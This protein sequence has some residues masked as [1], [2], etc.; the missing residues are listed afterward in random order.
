MCPDEHKPDARVRVVAQNPGEHEILGRRFVRWYKGEEGTGEIWEDYRPAPLIGKSGWELD[1]QFLPRAGLSRDDVECCNVV[2]CRLNNSNDLPPLT[3]TMAREMVTHCQRA[4]WKEPHD[5]QTMVA[6]G[7]YALWALTGE[8]EGDDEDADAADDDLRASKSIDGWR[9][10]LL[11]YAPVHA[12]HGV[13]FM[14]PRRS[15]VGD[16]PGRS[17]VFATYHPAFYYR[18]HWLKPVGKADFSK[19]GR[20]LRGVWPEPFPEMR[21]G[22]APIVPQ[23]PLAFDTEYNPWT[24]E[25]HRYSLAWRSQDRPVVWVTEAGDQVGDHGY[26]RATTGGPQLIM[27]NAEAD[28][29]YTKSIFGA[30][31]TWWQDTMYAHA[32]L[33]GTLRHSLD[34]MGSLY[35]RHNRWKHLQQSDPL[36]YSGMDAL[37]TFDIWQQLQRELARDSASRELYEHELKPLLPHV[38]ARPSI[39]LDAMHIAQAAQELK[40]EQEELVKRGQAVAGW[41][42]SISSPDQVARWLRLKTDAPF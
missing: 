27:Q 17:R 28:W 4:Y 2:R 39:R 12:T 15:D 41:P 24:R 26:D 1:N 21:Q 9:G 14:F 29:P 34:F 31:P 11:P 19:L 18:A 7:A 3:T 38:M 35:A 30:E 20:Y 10:W 42:L 13:D 37:A 16:T 5:S 6:L 22:M 40:R 23:W 36:T 25:L 33:Y 32:V 8:Y